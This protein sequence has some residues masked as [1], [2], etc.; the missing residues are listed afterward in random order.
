[1]SYDIVEHV[2]SIKLRFVD[3]VR[4]KMRLVASGLAYSWVGD[5]SIQ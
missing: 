4:F 3:R 2:N 1:M 5:P